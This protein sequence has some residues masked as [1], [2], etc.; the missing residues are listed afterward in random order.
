ME[1][2]NALSAG[3]SA[4]CVAKAGKQIPALGMMGRSSDEEV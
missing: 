1:G 4:G 3:E 2:R